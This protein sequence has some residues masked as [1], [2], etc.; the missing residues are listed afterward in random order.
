MTA[1]QYDSAIKLSTMTAMK[2]GGISLPEIIGILELAKINAERMAYAAAMDHQK[3]TAP[4]A[5][6]IIPVNGRIQPPGQ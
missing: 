2:S 6:N 3:A 4:E 5:P 1:Q